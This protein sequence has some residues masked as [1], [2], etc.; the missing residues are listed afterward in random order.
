MLRFGYFRLYYL[1]VRL[2]LVKFKLLLGK[3]FRYIG[4]VK[5]SGDTFF[6][7]RNCRFISRFIIVLRVGILGEIR[8]VGKIFLSVIRR[9]I[10]SVKLSASL[11]LRRFNRRVAQ[12]RRHICHCG[13]IGSFYF[14]YR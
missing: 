7:R 10:L 9:G 14:V 4:A 1:T 5:L 3:L 11:V 12:Y 8:V 6:R 2:N 13:C